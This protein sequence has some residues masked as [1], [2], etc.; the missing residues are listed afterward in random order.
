MRL[1]PHLLIGSVCLL[2]GL[3][4]L[5]W[6][7]L[8]LPGGRAT[9]LERLTVRPEVARPE[10]ATADAAIGPVVPTFANIQ[11][12]NPFVPGERGSRTGASLPDPPPPELELPAPPPTPFVGAGGK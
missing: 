12:V 5:G 10:V 8:S 3:G 1:T 2:T 6:I 11:G 7:G 9:P 4:I